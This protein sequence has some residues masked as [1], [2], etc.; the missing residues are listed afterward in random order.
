MYEN[1]LAE[2]A[3]VFLLMACLV[4]QYNFCWS[5]YSWRGSRNPGRSTRRLQPI[6]TKDWRTWVSS[7]LSLIGWERQDIH[8]IAWFCNSCNQVRNSDFGDNTSMWC[9]FPAGFEASL[10]YYDCHSWWLW[11]EG[12]ACLHYEAP[13]DGDDRRSGTFSWNGKLLLIILCICNIFLDH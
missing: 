9:A 11:L 10:C 13:S 5:F 1:I 6:C 8:I 12:D 7:F 2:L 3:S 4:N